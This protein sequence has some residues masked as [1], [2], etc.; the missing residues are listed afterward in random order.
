MASENRS[1]ILYILQIL[2]TITDVKHP[3]TIAMIQEQLKEGWG[4]DTHR[5]TVQNDIAA[6]V[7][8][9]YPIITVQ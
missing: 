6:L 3:A 1:R 2:Q 7:E 8:A 5:T 4:L 9:G